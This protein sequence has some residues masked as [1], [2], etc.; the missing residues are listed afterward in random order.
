MPRHRANIFSWHSFVF[1]NACIASIIVFGTIAAWGTN[2]AGL[3]LMILIFHGG[4]QLVTWLVAWKGRLLAAFLIPGIM[5][6]LELPINALL[7]LSVYSNADSSPMD[8]GGMFSTPFT[9]LG[10]VS[11]I[12]M[13]AGHLWMAISLGK[14][15]W[16][17]LDSK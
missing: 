14:L 5:F 10:F 9:T 8:D 1:T 16:E 7:A 3:V 13:F 15:Y 2:R 11:S 4:L 17:S 6:M 12:G